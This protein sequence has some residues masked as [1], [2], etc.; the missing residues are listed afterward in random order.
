M[1]KYKNDVLLIAALLIVAGA[2]WL[3]MTLNDKSGAQAEISVDGA[4]IHTASLDE[5]TV[6]TV[7]DDTHYNIVAVKDGNV[8]VTEASCPDH[9]CIKQGQ[10]SKDGEMIVCLPNKMIITITGGET[11]ADAEAK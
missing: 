4:V 11:G 5:N 1:R 9:T 7:G 3:V 8:C 2:V 10:K 6:I